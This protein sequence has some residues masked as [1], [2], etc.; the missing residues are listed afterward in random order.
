MSDVSQAPP[1]LWEIKLATQLHV[2]VQL[3]AAVAVCV[4][5]LITYYPFYER[6]VSLFSQIS[7]H[8]SMLL[9]IFVFPAKSCLIKKFSNSSLQ[10]DVQHI[11]SFPPM[12]WSPHRNNFNNNA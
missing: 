3:P 4:L 11:V 1:R 6:I 12:I 10:Q 5:S 2:Q 7:K 9:R 8:Q